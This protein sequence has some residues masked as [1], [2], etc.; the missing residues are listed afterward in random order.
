MKTLRLF[1]AGVVFAT[2]ALVGGGALIAQNSAG[3]AFQPAFD[4]IVSGQWTWR[5]V[6][7][8]VIEGATD[9]AFETTVTF[10]EPTADRTWT[11]SNI[12]DT[13]VGLTATQTLTN[14]TLTSPTVTGATLTGATLTSPIITSAIVPGG[15]TELIT[16]ATHAGGGCVA[17]DTASG[18]VVTLPAATGSGNRYCFV[19]TVADSGHQINVVGN[20]EFV[21][22]IIQGNDSDNTTVMWP[23]TDAAD[24]DRIAPNGTT[25]GGVVGAYY[26]LIDIST[27]NWM[28]IGWSDASSTEATPFA[29]GQV[30]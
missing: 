14:K 20:D 12:S 3:G 5:R 4:Y 26:I 24:N 9:D 18:T 6:S 21:G 17:L 13:V 23:A 1:L 8:F 22:G 2:L 11:F 29:T 16:A 28:V 25:R 19:V 10:A 27:D 15:A 7:P 30:S